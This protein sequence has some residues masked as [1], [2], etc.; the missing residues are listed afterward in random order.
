MRQKMEFKIM[1][2]EERKVFVLQIP[3]LQ[4]QIERTA[5]ALHGLNHA[6]KFL[7]QKYF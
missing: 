6:I 2:M 5:L 4:D 7:N 1:E 3:Q